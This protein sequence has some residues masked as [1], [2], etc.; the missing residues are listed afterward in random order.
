M[1]TKS[2]QPMPEQRVFIRRYSK[3]I[4]SG[5]AALF[6]GAGL[7]RSAGYVDWKGL[8]EGI[9]VELE[10]DINQEADLVA[11]AQYYLNLKRNRSLLNE[12]IIDEFARKAEPTQNH[13]LL[14]RLPIHNIWTA[15]YDQ[16]IEKAFEEAGKLIDVKL[17]DQNFSIRRGGDMILYKMHGDVTNPHLAMLTKD[18]YERY[19]LSH[20][21]FVAH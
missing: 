2:W 13:Y 10:L 3:Y 15:N 9:A 20:P 7:S 4:E 11:V 17:T 19:Q 1:Q 5:E 12:A 8:L 16:L 14:A 6:A 21:M 18:D